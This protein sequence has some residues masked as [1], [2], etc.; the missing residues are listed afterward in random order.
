[1]SSHPACGHVCRLS[2]G[3]SPAVA[4]ATGWLVL[5]I[6]PSLPA[7]ALAEQTWAGVSVAHS[8]H[9]LTCQTPAFMGGCEDRDTRLRLHIGQRLHRHLALELAYTDLGDIRRDGQTSVTLDAGGPSAPLDF[10]SRGAAAA[11]SLTA[12]GLWQ[13]DPQL[14]LFGRLGV[15]RWRLDVAAE[16]DGQRAG[17]NLSGYDP[18]L[19]LGGLWHFREQWSLRA[20]WERLFD[21]G[22]DRS[23]QFRDVRLR[24]QA[25]T[26]SDVA[27]VVLQGEGGDVDVFSLGLQYRY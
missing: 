8:S 7:V 4:R 5:A 1:M 9:E 6:L 3:G 24:N 10:R 27:D 20:D 19:G 17:N 11:L 2:R 26:A 18:V 16:L 14:E 13:P 23:L 12:V 22:G 25:G 21:V 15:A